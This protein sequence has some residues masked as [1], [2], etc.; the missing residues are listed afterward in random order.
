MNKK[1]QFSNCTVHILM[2]VGIADGQKFQIRTDKRSYATAA[3]VSVFLCGANLTAWAQS[4]DAGRVYD[5]LQKRNPQIQQPKVPSVN[6]KQETP[7]AAFSSTTAT[8]LEVKRFRIEGA[9]LLAQPRLEA[10][11]K[12]FEE[13]TLTV[14]QLQEAA[15]VI[16]RLY[17]DAGYLLAQA[18]VLPQAIQNGEVTITVR[19]GRLERLNVVSTK[20]DQSLPTLV[21]S[22]LQQSA[23]EGEA[24]NTRV[25]EE[26]LLLVNDLPGQAR[27][28]AEIAPGTQNDSSTL[29]INYAAAPRVGGSVQLDNDGGRYTGRNRLFG[30]LYV[31]EPLGLG[32]QA[33]VS[34]LSTGALLTSFQLGYRVPVGLRTTLGVSASHLKYDLCCL[35]ND[36]TGGGS[37]RTYGLELAHNLRLRRNQQ[38]SLFAN[39]DGK[40]LESDSNAVQQTQRK[41]QGVSLGVRGFWSGAAYNAWSL[42]WRGGRANLQNNA[43]DLAQDEAG[44]HVQGAYSKL[45]ASY[46]RNQAL[47]KAWSWRLNLRGQANLGRNLE[48]SER[49]SLG[50]S[51]GLR[52]YPSGEAIADS[53]WLATLELRYALVSVQGLSV[54]GF[55]DT[56]GIKRYSKDADALAGTTPNSYQLTGA[57]L[58]LRYET[59]DASVSLTLAKPVGSNRGLDAES[60]N[61]EGRGDGTRALLSAAWRF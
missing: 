14:E 40:R 42:A 56:G 24:I 7:E 1:T 2:P 48:S 50:G 38:L 33:S 8:Q 52:G 5:S 16:T 15:D 35:L 12:P 36:Q 34:A 29:S 11:I 41:V 26:T 13:R 28:S 18:Q 61:S 9:E 39:V 55:V 17:H 58:G 54:T 53:G 3:L 46:Y 57:G 32:D 43:A 37:A 4:I 20:P 19:E 25:L 44:A 23:R 51:D 6:L 59:P 21:R 47:N 45:S 60:N 31:N 22:G 10:A 30:Q 27:A 49:F